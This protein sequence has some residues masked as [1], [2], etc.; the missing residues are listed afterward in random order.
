MFAK[1]IP[2]PSGSFVSLSFFEQEVKTIDEI[3]RMETNFLFITVNFLKPKV[4][5]IV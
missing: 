5:R 4:I 2:T 3:K 1:S